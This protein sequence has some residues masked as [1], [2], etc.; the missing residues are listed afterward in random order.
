MQI[1]GIPN[2]KKNPDMFSVINVDHE[3]A[4]DLLMNLVSFSVHTPI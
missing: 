3:V 2:E 1:V 4:Y